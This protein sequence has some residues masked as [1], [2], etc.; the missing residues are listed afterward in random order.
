MT[1]TN[2]QQHSG[3]ILGL[4]GLRALSVLAVFC[5]H[6]GLTPVTGGFVGVD[7]FFV[8]SGFLITRL[9][10]A[11]FNS[12][13]TISFSS[14]Y[15]RRARRLYPALLLMVFG[16]FVYFLEFP[17][18][19]DPVQEIF[20]ALFY[21][22]N[23]VR[24][25]RGYDAF[26]TA[27]TW[28][29]AIEEQFYLLWP[30]VLTVLLPFGNARAARA[31]AAMIVL[32]VAWR[33]LLVATHATGARLYTG[34]DTRADGLMVGA[35]LALAYDRVS[36]IAASAWFAGAAY[37]ICVLFVQSV[38][39]FSRT[40]LGYFVSAVAAMCIVAKISRDQNSA[41]VKVLNLW[42]LSALGVTSYGFYL[43]HYPMVQ[44]M[45]YGGHQ[46][47][48]AFFGSFEHPRVALFVGSF[49]ASVG[50]ATASWFL[51]E[52]PILRWGSR[53]RSIGTT[54]A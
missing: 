15:L 37:L 9:L 38:T 43:F 45:L 50:A 39:S 52:K 51:I 14:F 8:L 48:G 53:K 6:T 54:P 26:L 16:V 28:T 7:V 1:N 24:A 32:V 3:R 46:T 47:M 17:E 33:F 29:L 25:F 18:K 23:W 27:H 4:D 40:P 10:A 13:G 41:L 5:T 49:C 22:M 36:R 30:L 35:F 20:P 42:P 21:Y 44:T 2:G 31:I 19:H 11:E 12:R 34:F